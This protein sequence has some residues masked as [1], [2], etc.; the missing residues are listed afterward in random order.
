MFDTLQSKLEKAFK[1]LKGQ[2]SINDLN[3]AE[4]VREI[5]RA[6]ISADFNFK[7]AKDFTDK[8]LEE[9]R[10]KNVIKSVSPGQQLT[11]IV[12]DQLVDLLGSTKSDL[13]LTGNPA[14]ILIAGLQG[15]GKTTFT[16]KLGRLLKS[17]GKSPLLVACDV[18]RPAARE[19]LRVLGEGIGVPVYSEDD[20]Q[21]VNSIAENAIKFA[22]QNS[23]NVV[24]IDTAG[25]LTVDEA[26]MAEILGLKKH[27]K[28]SEILFVVDSMI[29]QDAVTTAQAFNETLDFTGVVLTKLDGDTRGGAALSIKK[30]VN[31]PIKFIS[32]GEKMEALEVFHPDRMAGRILG[33]GDVVSLVERAQATIDEDEAARLSKK[34]AKN[35]FDFEDFLSQLNQIKKMGNMKD[36][37]GMI[38]GVGSKV[39][40]LDIDDDAFKGIESLIQSMTPEERQKPEILS[41][42][43]K[44]RIANGSGRSVTELNKLITQ[45]N[46]MRQMMK[47]MNKGKGVPGKRR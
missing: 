22:K 13:T 12:N 8:I 20:S 32:N 5:R 46:Q 35:K 45:F 44:Q 31:K 6:L 16:G 7:V 3:V 38:P 27:T 29:G 42:S 11:K 14:I 36:L 10:G 28:P 40:D 26:M 1:N 21:N 43:R 19:Q 4:T 41:G 47:M 33:I 15:S 39:K 2:G 9:A 25:R 17:Q 30:Q 18:Y 23:H 37:L 34:M 24:L